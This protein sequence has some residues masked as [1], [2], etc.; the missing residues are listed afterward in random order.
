MTTTHPAQAVAARRFKRLSREHAQLLRALILDLLSKRPRTRQDLVQATQ[1]TDGAVRHQVYWLSELG[2]IQAERLGDHALWSVTEAYQKQRAAAAAA[3]TAAQ[4]T[5]KPAPDA[6][7]DTVPTVHI[8]SPAAWM[9]PTP[10]VRVVDGVRITRQAA[11]A[12][13]FT[14]ALRDGPGT[15]VI[16]QDNPGLASL[17]RRTPTTSRRAA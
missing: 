8:T 16:S 10:E 12:P 7:D 2:L 14:V 11:P 4:P 15:G 1:A 13:R 6:A 17:A 3:R 5:A 9:L